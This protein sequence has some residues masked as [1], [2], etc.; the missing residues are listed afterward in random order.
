MHS[1]YIERGVVGVYVVLPAPETA[2]FGA[3]NI[4]HVGPRKLFMSVGVLAWAINFKVGS[5]IMIRMPTILLVCNVFIIVV[6]RI[7]IQ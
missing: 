6:L 3:G 5:S 1:C 7:I 2:I 4:K